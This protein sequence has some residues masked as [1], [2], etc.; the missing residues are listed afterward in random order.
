[1]LQEIKEGFLHHVCYLRRGGEKKNE[2]NARRERKGEREKSMVREVEGKDTVTEEKP[3]SHPDISR[4]QLQMFSRADF[5]VNQ[6]QLL[7][8]PLVLLQGAEE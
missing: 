8:A 4:G 5:Q 3:P 2:A 7:R 6:T 1:M